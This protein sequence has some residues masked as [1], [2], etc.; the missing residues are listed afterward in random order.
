MPLTLIFQAAAAVAAAAAVTEV[1]FIPMIPLLVIVLPTEKMAAIASVVVI[2]VVGEGVLGA[3]LEEL[4]TEVVK[5]VAVA[6]MV[7]ASDSWQSNV[8]KRPVKTAAGQ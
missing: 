8:A 5:E 2:V 7:A 3:G 4:D 1:L 6:S